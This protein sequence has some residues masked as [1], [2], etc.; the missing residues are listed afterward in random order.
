MFL[1][2]P[3][4]RQ[5]GSATALKRG[6]LVT[7]V[8]TA[9]SKWKTLDQEGGGQSSLARNPVDPPLDQL[10]D[11]MITYMA[12]IQVSIRMPLQSCQFGLAMSW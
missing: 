10:I 3:S 6:Y 9:E 7:V 12:R 4:T 1:G 2:P 5:N 11:H 8:S